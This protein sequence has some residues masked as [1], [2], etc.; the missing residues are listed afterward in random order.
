MRDTYVRAAFEQVVSDA[1]TAKSSYVSLYVKLPY[2]G[3][4]EEGGWWG[5]DLELV[6]YRKCSNDV[7]AKAIRDQVENLAEQLSEQS[8]QR[9]NEQCAREV[10]W[11]EERD[12]M[13]EASDYFP[14]VDGEESY[15]VVTES[16]P[17]SLVSQGSRHYE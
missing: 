15:W 9:F 6:S 1:Q 10:E 13:A 3:G 14:E 2:Y 4:P 12:P 17:G 11:V 5:Y 16:R 8:R 7:E